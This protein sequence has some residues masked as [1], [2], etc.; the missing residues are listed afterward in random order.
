MVVLVTRYAGGWMAETKKRVCKKCGSD[1]M[2]KRGSLCR[3]CESQRV[4]E[5]RRRSRE[6]K[7][8][9]SLPSEPPA[10]DTPAPRAP[11]T[12]LTLQQLDALYIKSAAVAADRGAGYAHDMLRVLEHRGLT[13]QRVGGDLEEAYRVIEQEVPNIRAIV[14]QA[15][16]MGLGMGAGPI[17]EPPTKGR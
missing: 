6:R 17:P 8:M 2:P 1:D 12:R 4:S 7:R 9:M 16:V 15:K 13:E 10:V 5:S 14:E 11:L 3:K